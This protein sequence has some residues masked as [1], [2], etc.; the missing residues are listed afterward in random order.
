MQHK[1]NSCIFT[2]ITILASFSVC[3]ASQREKATIRRWN[4]R[5]DSGHASSQT[6][7]NRPL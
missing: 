1:K 5:N 2:C 3:Q 6:R 4:T 7:K